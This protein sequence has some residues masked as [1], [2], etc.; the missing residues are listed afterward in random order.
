MLEKMA[1]LPLVHQ[2]GTTFEYSMSID[3]LGAI[4][5]IVSGLDLQRFIVE[6][7]AQPLGMH[8]TAFA[9]ADGE[10]LA[11]PQID[12]ATG[13]RTDVTFLYDHARPGRWF[14]G[15][16][17]ILTTAHDYYRF[18]QMLLGNGEVDGVRILARK[19]VALMTSDHLPP[20]VRYGSFTRALGITA[21]LPEFGQ[22]FGLGVAVRTA[23]GRNPNPGSV[24][25]YC[26]S[27]I[28][29]TYFWIDPAEELIAIYLMQAPLERIH[30]RSLMRNMV[31]A[32]L[33]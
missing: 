1:R 21:P 6:R 25:D 28:S 20:G 12:P 31:Y 30:Y 18:A 15:G 24:G 7:I 13:K 29:G 10:R 16:G 33:I 8:D 2:P 3:V 22:G 17:G 9:T 26:W 19:S 11:E 14:S 23:P 4:V 27:G 5:E 32:S